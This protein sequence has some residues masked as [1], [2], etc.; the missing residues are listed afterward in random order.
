M[1]PTQTIEHDYDDLR[2]NKLVLELRSLLDTNFVYYQPPE[3]VKIHYP[4]VII[5]RARPF[6][7]YANNHNYHRRQLF[8]LTVIDKDPDSPYIAAI[9]D[10]YEYCRVAN[11]FTKD[12][13]NHDVIELYY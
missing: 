7:L 3:S 13:L 12:D 2:S 1:A 5:K 4:C 6:T 11:H 8:E 10:H 9:A